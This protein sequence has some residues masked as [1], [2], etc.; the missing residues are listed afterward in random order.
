MSKVY[1]FNRY[2]GPESQE[3]IERPIPVPGPGELGVKVRAAAVNPE[4]WKFRSGRLGRNRVLPA[5]MGREVAGTIAAMGDGVEGF[6]VGDAILG[7]VA[8]GHGGFA[9]DTIVRAADAVAKPDEISFSD[10]ATIPVAAATAYDGTHQIEL[11]AGQTL[12]IL[13]IGGG[14]GLMAAQIGRVHE[15]IVIGTGSES[16]R[17]IVESTGAILVPTG[18]ALLTRLREAAPDGVDL[19]L[20]LVGGDALREVGELVTS[21]TKIISAADPSAATE[22]GGA[23]LERTTEAMA[24][25]TSVIEYGLVN[26]HVTA[27]YPLALADEAIAVVEDGHATGKIVLEIGSA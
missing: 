14:V 27:L 7:S 12:L 13:G 25:I 5:P 24:K 8:P 15:L 26:P 16:K 21:P 18:E 1:V 22:L 23:A 2:G 19:I 6:A 11:Q 17:D 9:E 3:L 4:D 20:D 10:A